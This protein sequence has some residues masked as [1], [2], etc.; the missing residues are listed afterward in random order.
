MDLRRLQLGTTN[1][2]VYILGALD[3]TMEDP[4]RRLEE[5]SG[6]RSP[7]RLLR[8]AQQLEREIRGIRDVRDVIFKLDNVT[9]RGGR[10]RMRGDPEL[11]RRAG[12]PP[13][14]GV[15]LRTTGGGL[16][17]GSTT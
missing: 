14:G 6:C 15:G 13:A 11:V 2:V 3:T 8:L 12:A 7:E 16:E 5:G 17:K 9:K 4:R 10:W 1:G